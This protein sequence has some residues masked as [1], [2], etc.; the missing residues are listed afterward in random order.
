MHKFIKNNQKKMLAVFGVLLMIV[1]IIPSSFRNS[2]ER[3]RRAIGKIGNTPVY[4][5]E[6]KELADE[7]GMLKR[8]S[9]QLPFVNEL[10]FPGGVPPQYRQFVRPDNQLQ[11][12]PL[13]YKLGMLARQIDEHP[14]LYLLLKLEAERRELWFQTT[15]CARWS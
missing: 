1:F 9:V 15:Q 6:R 4:D 8:V 14:D 13:T 2:R 10:I 11:T 12:V 5:D 7:W 3:T